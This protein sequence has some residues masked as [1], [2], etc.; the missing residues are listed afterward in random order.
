MKNFLNNLYIRLV[1][2]RI[3]LF[4]NILVF[5]YIALIVVVAL[6]L[7]GVIPESVPVFGQFAELFYFE[8]SSLSAVC[9]SLLTI[10]SIMVSIYVIC[11]RVKKIGLSDIKSKKVKV[12]MATSGLRF[13]DN[14]KIVKNTT[15]KKTDSNIPLIN[16][17]Q[18]LAT[19]VSADINKTKAQA[20]DNGAENLEEVVE[21]ENQ[22]TDEIV[23]TE[24]T[25]KL[26]A[27]IFGNM[28][29]YFTKF[30]TKLTDSVH[31]HK[32][33]SKSKHS[34]IDEALNDVATKLS[35]TAE[36]IDTDKDSFKV[37]TETKSEETTTK[38]EIKPE[39]SEEHSKTEEVVENKP[40]VQAAEQPKPAP[41]QPEQRKYSSSQQNAFDAFKS[42]I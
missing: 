36:N 38:T 14:G 42:S 18:E 23:E 2:F 29:N 25:L 33:M 5:V 37:V 27:K 21:T 19:I 30:K 40:V 22:T 15:V 11:T 41:K 24:S 28:K 34:E 12:M 35:D 17:A 20:T 10:S 3:W 1:L 31:K 32:K 26:H 6:I 8:D 16:A 13:N 39:P 4:K 9:T 7:A